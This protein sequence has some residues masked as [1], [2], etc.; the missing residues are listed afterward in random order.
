MEKS[1]LISKLTE[2]VK[3]VLEDDNAEVD[4]DKNFDDLG[5]DSMG[6]VEFLGLIEDEY[7]IDVDEDEIEEINTINEAVEFIIK[8]KSNEQS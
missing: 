2:F 8:K 6:T 7:G 4:A 3:E 5:L 1:E